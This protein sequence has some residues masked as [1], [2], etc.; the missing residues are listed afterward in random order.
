MLH[1]CIICVFKLESR[2]FELLSIPELEMRND[3]LFD[4]ID[5]ALVL[6]VRHLEVLELG[7]IVPIDLLQVFHLAQHHKLLLVNDIIWGSLVKHVLLFKLLITDSDLSLV[8]F[9]VK[10][11]LQLIDLLFVT[12]NFCSDLSN[13]LS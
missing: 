1:V 5:L 2:V 9:P 6:R 11:H 7:E 3:L 8:L 12:I 4:H 10:S 13:L